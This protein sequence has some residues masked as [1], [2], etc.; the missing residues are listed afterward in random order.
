M[1]TSNAPP[2]VKELKS[3]QDGLVD[4][5]KNIKFKRKNNQFQNKLRADLNNIRKDKNIYVAAD[6]T[7]NFYKMSKDN[8]TNFLNNNITKDYKKADES[9]IEAITKKDMKIASELEIDDRIYTTTK[10]DSFITIKDHKENFLNNP[11]FRLINPTKAELGM[12][13]KQMLT[14]I[15]STV[16]RKSHLVQWKNSDS[17][18]DWFTNLKNKEK[19]HFLQFDVV[20]FYASITPKLLENSLTFAAKYITINKSTKDTIL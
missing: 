4:M 7:R 2:I 8:Y 1:N 18:I 14:E 10:R 3:L 16:K 9:V 6:K 11:K 5:A 19:M 20:D 15:I 17:T 12:I 13:S